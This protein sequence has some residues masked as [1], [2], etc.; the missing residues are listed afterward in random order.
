VDG[1][2]A[3]QRWALNTNYFK[4]PL[5]SPSDASATLPLNPP[6]GIASLIDVD[7]DNN[8]T[9]DLLYAGD[10]RGNLWKLDLSSGTA[11]SATSST[12]GSALKLNGVATPRRLH[13]VVRDRRVGRHR[14]SDVYLA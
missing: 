1:P 4:I 8:G 13:G 11:P 7:R 5:P 10:R 9:V 12:W 14:R 6:N 3:G 2:G